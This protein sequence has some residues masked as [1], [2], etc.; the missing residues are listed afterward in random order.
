[1]PLNKSTTY[2]PPPHV[3]IFFAS[4]NIPQSDQRDEAVILSHICWGPGAPTHPPTQ[5][6]V[7]KWEGVGV[8]PIATPSPVVLSM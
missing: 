4:T 7:R 3:S 6:V 1:M 2:H 5:K 8:W